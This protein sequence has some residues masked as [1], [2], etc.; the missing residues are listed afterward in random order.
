MGIINKTLNRFGYVTKSAAK[1][2]VDR[3]KKG[4]EKSMDSVITLEME[5]HS[6][7]LENIKLKK[8]NEAFKKETQSAID[9]LKLAKNVME[10]KG[11][12][13]VFKGGKA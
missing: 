9:S 5:L 2:K 8:E 6:L 3:Y 4:Y 13:C 12:F 11:K 1:K 7:K 10:T